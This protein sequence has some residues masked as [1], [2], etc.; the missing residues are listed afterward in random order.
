[1]EQQ[2]RIPLFK[3]HL[4]E[5]ELDQIRETFKS[6]WVG[7]GPKTAEFERLIAEYTGANHA[8]CTNSCT[9]ALHLAL[10]VLGVSGK[11]VLLPSLTFV[12]TAHAVLHAGGKPVWVDVDE[13]T[14]CL[15][16]DALRK[17]IG[18]NSAC[19]VPVHYAGHPCEMD[20]ILEIAEEKGIHVVEDAAQAFGAEYRGKKVGSLGSDMTCFS[21]HATK[22]I[23]TGEGGAITTDSGELNTKLRQYRFLGADRDTWTRLKEARER[24]WHFICEDVGY[25]Y[26]MNDIAAA[27]GIAQLQKLPVILERKTYLFN[28]YTEKLKAI[29]HLRVPTIH[30]HVKP[31]AYSYVIKCE[32]R[33]ELMAF[34]SEKGITT[35]VHYMPVHLQPA[36]K[37]Y[38]KKLPVTE[39]I[40]QQI[41][42][43]PL[44]YTLKEE[45]Q[46]YI[47]EMI[48]E[49]Y[50]H[51]Q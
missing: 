17:K 34:L 44:Y 25:K 23:T 42:T 4:G 13:E 7:L 31:S 41:L 28:R 24:Y 27:I 10:E 30:P 26:Y 15:S 14:L 38:R 16:P 5:E 37:R 12:A 18:R 19:I 33:D 40:W 39:K 50:R 47:V 49:F 11:D 48:E 36:Y 3:P 43:L 20:E 51:R 1:M 6:G 2:I 21:F 32:R 46:D 35:G 9:S 22:N 45:E 29:P 8:I